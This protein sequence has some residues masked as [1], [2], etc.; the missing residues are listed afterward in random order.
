M[1]GSISQFPRRRSGF[2]LVELLVVISIIALLISILLPSLRGAREQAKSLK[3]LAHARGLA[4]AGMTFANDHNDRFQLVT[5]EAG[6][7]AA[8]PQRS[9]YEYDGAGELLSWITALAQVTTKGGFDTNWSWGVRAGSL[10][11]A[12]DREEF[13]NQDFELALCPSDKVK[14]ST[15]FYPNGPQLLGPGNP[16]DP[17]PEG[18]GLYWGYLSYGI[19]EDLTGAQD[20]F[21]PLPPVG[22]YD[23]NIPQAWRRGQSSPFAAERLEGR[24]ERAHDPATVLLITDAGADSQEEVSGDATGAN[25]RADGVVN[26]IIS[27]QATGPLL[28]HAQDKW[29]QRIPSKRH[30]KGAVNVVFADFHGS[31]ARPTGY[32]KSSADPRLTTPV[33]HSTPVRVSPYKITGPVRPLQ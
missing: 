14:V 26:L 5:S 27:A 16:A 12:L 23:P 4:Q 30:V 3:C 15:P 10:A 31:T 33:G 13:M 29:P 32:R 25:S 20:G 7:D 9:K 28:A 21:S 8:D 24:L 17:Q 1:C 2:T 6:N 11:Q 22:R 18:A 19:N